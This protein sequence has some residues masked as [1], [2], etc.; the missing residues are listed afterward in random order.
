MQTKIPQ[1]NDRRLSLAN[2]VN[3]QLEIKRQNY[4]QNPPAKRSSPN[5]QQ[6]SL[7]PTTPTRKESFDSK[8]IRFS[9]IN[10]NDEHS[11]NKDLFSFLTST[12]SFTPKSQIVNQVRS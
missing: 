2:L 9:Q 3:A 5:N 10:E 8:T 1:F 4:P 11:S 7:T 6:P 12:S